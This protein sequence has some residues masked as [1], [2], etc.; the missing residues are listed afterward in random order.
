MLN[1]SESAL[2]SEYILSVE[3]W[4]RPAAGERLISVSRAGGNVRLADGSALGIEFNG[5]RAPRGRRLFLL[6][7]IAGTSGFHIAHSIEIE[8]A[9]VYPRFAEID[10]GYLPEELLPDKPLDAAG[11]LREL[12][13]TGTR[14]PAAARWFTTTRKRRRAST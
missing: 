12:A 11:F 2:F 10:V 9:H 6:T 1:E 14:C 7:R 5:S 4:I 8:S 13:L 3:E